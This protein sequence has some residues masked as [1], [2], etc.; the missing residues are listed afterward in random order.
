MADYLDYLDIIEEENEDKN[1]SDYDD[2]KLSPHFKEKLKSQNK[3]NAK[4]K[5]LAKSIRKMERKDR[6]A[7]YQM[8]P[9]LMVNHI[10]DLGN[11]FDEEA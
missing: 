3:K 11:A 7:R 9:T 5:N 8:D 2:K 6:S 10:D 1:S 4:S